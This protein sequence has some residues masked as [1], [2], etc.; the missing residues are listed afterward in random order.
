MGS[1]SVSSRNLAC[2]LGSCHLSDSCHAPCALPRLLLTE[3]LPRHLCERTAQSGHPSGL[4]GCPTFRCGSLPSPPPVRT[5]GRGG[6]AAAS[7]VNQSRPI[8]CLCLSDGGSWTGGSFGGGDRG[9]LCRDSC[10]LVPWLLTLS[11]WCSAVLGGGAMLCL[12]SRRSC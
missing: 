9:R 11:S 3:P 4:A 6:A 10:H 5:V 7:R 8:C 1:G 12:H 2:G